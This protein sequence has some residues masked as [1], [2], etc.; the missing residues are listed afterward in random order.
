MTPLVY[1]GG[2]GW[3]ARRHQDRGNVLFA[4]GRVRPVT[5][6]LTTSAGEW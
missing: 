5:H 4:D 6:L 3:F 2:P 1:E